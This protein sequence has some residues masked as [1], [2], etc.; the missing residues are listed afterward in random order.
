MAAEEVK[1]KNSSKPRVILLVSG[2]RKSGKDFITD[3]LQEKIGPDSSVIIKLSGPIKFHWAKSLD[4]DI[5]QL[6]G[7]GKY[8][9]T[10]RLEM[11]KW[12]EN[13]RKNDYGYFCRAAI[14]MYHAYSKPIWIVSDVRRKT[15]IQWFV[16]N[17]G[18][19]CKTIHIVSDDL[20]REKRGWTFM[21]GIDDS[22]SECDLDDVKSWDL[23][24]INNGDN[25]EY[26]LQQILELIN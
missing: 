22:E 4:L 19:I 20:I 23:K 11:A 15:D 2:K 14:D 18:G 3:I 7:D 5:D 21:P 24:V 26:I 13:I 6:L 25:V 1:E 12:G 8:K 16:E 10:Y 17:F 9:E